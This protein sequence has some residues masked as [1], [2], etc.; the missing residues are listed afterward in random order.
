MPGDDTQLMQYICSKPAAFFVSV[1][2][3]FA[4]LTFEDL[5]VK[6]N[7]EIAGT[8]STQKRISPPVK[9]PIPSPKK[10]KEDNLIPEPAHVFIDR[11][12][13]IMP[14][15]QTKCE[16]ILDQKYLQNMQPLVSDEKKAQGYFPSFRPTNF[17][18]MVQQCNH[19]N[20]LKPQVIPTDS[21]NSYINQITQENLQL[22]VSLNERFA[23]INNFCKRLGS[24]WSALNS[25]QKMDPEAASHWS[26]ILTAGSA[27]QHMMKSMI[28]AQNKSAALMQ[29][30]VLMNK[31]SSLKQII[32]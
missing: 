6:E 31:I 16:E 2:H 7:P 29:Y 20:V 17:N 9:I 4:K 28:A 23:E 3:R 30:L 13:L 25:S 32:E 10:K 19:E 18:P 12:P 1:G 5:K 14:Q 11:R 24:D 21:A 26:Y 22:K 8:D 27:L 15:I